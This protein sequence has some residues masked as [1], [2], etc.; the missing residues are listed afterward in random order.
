MPY[1]PGSESVTFD[2]GLADAAAQRCT[3]AATSLH[4]ATGRRHDLAA[5]AQ[6]QWKGPF[7]DRFDGQLHSIETAAGELEADLR[8]LAGTI[9][10]AA[11]A[12]RLENQRRSGLRAQ[13][14]HDHPDEFAPVGV[15]PR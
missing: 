1:P 10:S 4:H 12:A 6:S 8:R 7:R 3:H 15:G 5:A 9:R 14:R 2:Y 11:E 13:Y